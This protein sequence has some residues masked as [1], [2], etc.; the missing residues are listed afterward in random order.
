M[1]GFYVQLTGFDISPIEFR[2]ALL[3]QSWDIISHLKLETI[4]Y[5][6]KVNSYK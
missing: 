1:T 2:M 4:C 3:H 5:I 6:F